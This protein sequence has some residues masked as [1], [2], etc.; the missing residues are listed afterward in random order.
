MTLKK[1]PPHLEMKAVSGRMTLKKRPPHL[2]MKAVSGRR[3]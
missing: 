3:Q 2:E 1:R